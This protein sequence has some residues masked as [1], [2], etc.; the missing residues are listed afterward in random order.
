MNYVYFTYKKDDINKC[1]IGLTKKPIKSKYIGS[2]KAIKLA[3]K[4]YG[5]NSF[6][7]LNFNS[8]KCRKEAKCWEEFYIKLCK[9]EKK[10][11][12]YNISPTG[13]LDNGGKHSK[14]TISK[15]VLS[16]KGY[17]H[18]KE[19]I[20]KIKESQIGKHVSN[21]TKL[22]ISNANKGRKH[23]KIA[24]L[25]IKKNHARPNLDK[26]LSKETRLKISKSQTGRKT[27]KETRLKMSISRIGYKYKIV[28]CPHCGKE[29]GES[30]MKSWHFNNCKKIKK[31][32]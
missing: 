19:T 15:I 31:I 25:K 20:K 14:E 26:T 27:S 17:K 30:G 1:Y 32:A 29:G 4:K 21:E 24:K 18:S 13:G 8:F 28:M 23:T 12:G 9:T 7:R 5:R 22:K 16:R 11:G 3:I 2:G 6:V 10:F